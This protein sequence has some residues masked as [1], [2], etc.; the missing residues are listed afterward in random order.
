MAKY[1]ADAVMVSWQVFVSIA[2]DEA[3]RKGA[4]FENIDEGGD[5]MEDVA[6]VWQADK[7]RYKQL[8]E[9]QAR[10]EISDMVET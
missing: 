9:Q 10:N 4:E 6:A 2:F 8:T 7:E 5:F 3:K 1:V